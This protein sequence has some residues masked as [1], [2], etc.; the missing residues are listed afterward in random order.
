[1]RFTAPWVENKR[2]GVTQTSEFI[3]PIKEEETLIL[4]KAVITIC[5]YTSPKAYGTYVRNLVTH[6]PLKEGAFRSYPNPEEDKVIM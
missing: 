3:A 6:S 2:N 5:H 4:W 1:M